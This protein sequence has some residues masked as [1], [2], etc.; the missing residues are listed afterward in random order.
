MS[1]AFGDGG[2]VRFP[3]TITITVTVIMVAVV[4]GNH[5]HHASLG[6]GRA[7]DTALDA[8]ASC[9]PFLFR[10]SRGTPSRARYVNTAARPSYRRR[11]ADT[12]ARTK[13]SCDMLR[14]TG[15]GG[16]WPQAGPPWGSPVAL[17]LAAVSPTRRRAPP[18]ALH[19]PWRDRRTGRT[20]E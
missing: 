15:S 19:G 10:T 3:K 4:D 9:T 16:P 14:P 1:K 7:P 8:R 2:H 11:H 17:S 20:M 5:T 18:D 13:P 12:R 6:Y